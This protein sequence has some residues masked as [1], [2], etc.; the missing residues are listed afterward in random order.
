MRSRLRWGSKSAPLVRLS[1]VLSES[2]S[3]RHWGYDLSKR[4]RLRAGVLYPLL[5]RMVASGLL[6]SAWETPTDVG[7]R[8]PPRR[9]YVLT[10]VGL[11]EVREIAREGQAADQFSE[12][13][14]R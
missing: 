1:R 5:D 7:T 12:D 14:G 2:R 4:S 8:R 10:G 3:R 6:V 13:R 11:A 9:Y